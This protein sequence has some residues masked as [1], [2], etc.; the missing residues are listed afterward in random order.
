MWDATSKT[1]IKQILLNQFHYIVYSDINDTGERLV[2]Y[3][4][5][6]NLKGHLIL[7]DLIS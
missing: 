5:D 4:L 3:A 2:L 6:S 1:K 7:V